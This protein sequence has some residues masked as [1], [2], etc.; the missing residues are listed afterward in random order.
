MTSGGVTVL[1]GY[2]ADRDSGYGSEKGFGNSK[3][4]EAKAPS[5]EREEFP[6]AASYTYLP[7]IRDAQL[8]VGSLKRRLKDEEFMDSDAAKSVDSDQYYSSGGTSPENETDTT[9][10]SQ[11]SAKREDPV[12]P[13]ISMV[14]SRPKKEGDDDALTLQRHTQKDAR[15][16]VARRASEAGK[17]LRRRTWLVGSRSTSPTKGNAEEKQ[18][19][20]SVPP[21]PAK[22]TKP[23]ERRMSLRRRDSSKHREQENPS[24]TNETRGSDASQPPSVK[25]K[26]TL[27]KASRPSSL[28]LAE[29]S[30]SH[31]PP[32][33]SLPKSFSTD[34][35][36]ILKTPSSGTDRVPPVPRSISSEKLLKTDFGRKKDELWSVFRTLDGEYQKFQS[37]SI[38]LKANVVRTSLLPFLRQHASSNSHRNLR[39]EDLDRRCNILN[40]WWLGLLDMLQGKN[41]QSIS[42]TDRPVVLD[43]IAGIMERPE[44]R[45]YGTPFC[46]LDERSPP[47][48]TPRNKSSTSLLSENSDFLAESVYHNIRNTFVQNLMAQMVLVVDRMSLRN[49]SASLVS[50]CGKACAYAFFFCPGI[51]DVLVRLWDV[52]ASFLKRIVEAE[53]GKK[54]NSLLKEQSDLIAS[55]FPP[56]IQ[57]LS[58]LS[59]PKM[60]RALR[61]PTPVP[62]G[63]TN[64]NWYGFWVNRWAGRE[65]DLF[66]V[67]VKH[68][69]I[70]LTDYLAPNS[71][72]SE[73]LH[74][75]GVALVHA[76]T[77]VNLDSTIHRQAA[78]VAI[79]GNAGASTI[80][81]DDVLSDP[82]ASATPMPLPPTNATRLMAE[83]RLIMLIRDFLSER[84]AQHLA[85]RHIFAQ[86]FNDILQAAAQKTSLFDHKACYTLCDFLEEAFFIIVR[87]DSMSHVKESVL[88]WPFWLDVFRRMVD[89]QN[90]MTE[91]RLYAF[92]YGSWTS[93]TSDLQRQK[94]LCLD[95]LLEPS[96]FEGRFNHWCPMV[97]AY[98]MRLLCWRIARVDN[99]EKISDQ[100]IRILDVL[101][102]RLRTVWSHYLYIKEEAV[103]SGRLAPSTVPNNPAPHRRLFI[104]R[105]DDQVGPASN[106]LSFDGLVSHNPSSPPSPQSPPSRRDSTFNLL[107]ETGMRTLSSLTTRS[108]SDLESPNRSKWSLLKNFMSSPKSRSRSQSP[109]SISKSKDQDQ[110]L[111]LHSTSPETSSRQIQAPSKLDTSGLLQKQI[112]P[113]TSATHRSFCFKFSL[114]WPSK[115]T[116]SPQPMR[117]Y[118][119]RLPMNAQLFLQQHSANANA[120][121]QFRQLEPKGEAR[122]SSTYAGRSLAEWALVVGEY[123]AFVERRRAEGVPTAKVE[124]PTLGVE[125]FRRPG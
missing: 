63:T 64:V 51:A 40:R 62:L 42:G 90:T 112:S 52:P 53:N 2:S 80:T 60:M 123:Q 74:A 84:S 28:T 3:D 120:P 114:G 48:Q 118:P 4:Y 107:A 57:H 13:Q 45:S 27:G 22:S 29:K 73:R 71:T 66:Y 34:R 108:E 113:E 96:F 102:E 79:D 70:L 44:W 87:Y 111:R 14:R 19:A 68:F 12:I 16:P 121:S 103:A 76:Q 38:A 30:K 8:D 47:P 23:R 88:D 5:P 92:L 89:S 101:T 25:R 110:N 67:F 117:L 122:A 43:A 56:G 37:K 46:P 116:P 21:S 109:S 91:I 49:A 105:T 59:V 41:N 15:T 81:F 6:R 69:H 36:P 99:S 115:S 61:K 93:I 50:F 75:P 54:G 20:D 58:F 82:D 97:R 32:I 26:G 39:P 119:P 10:S 125:T 78:T 55:A 100:E 11:P 7:Q 86:G 95:F 9:Q 35:L 98:F 85:A 33:P 31:P 83:N 18:A 65:S 124:I 94:T 17:K 77:L 104:V 106:F 24:N 1:N 72:R